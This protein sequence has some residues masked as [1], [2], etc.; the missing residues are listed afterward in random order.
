MDRHSQLKRCWSS[1][2]SNPF[3]FHLHP[4]QRLISPTRCAKPRNISICIQIFFW[5]RY[6]PNTRSF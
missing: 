5:G 6:H 4:T 2:H 3:A 1:F